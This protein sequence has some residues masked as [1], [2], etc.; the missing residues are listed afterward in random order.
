MIL[1]GTG[2]VHLASQA[3]RKSWWGF[4]PTFLGAAIPTVMEVG[5][6][7]AVVN[8]CKWPRK[9]FPSL[10]ENCLPGLFATELNILAIILLAFGL[11]WLTRP[12]RRT[13]TW[14][15]KWLLD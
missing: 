6:D 1:E 15:K 12:Y 7:D 14:Q 8:I 2:R 13:G 9:F 11:V 3:S 4:V 10:A 5:P